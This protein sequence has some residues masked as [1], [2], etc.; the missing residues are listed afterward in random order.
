M[1]KALKLTFILLLIIFPSKVLAAG[2]SVSPSSISMTTG[3]TKTFS[4]VCTDCE[5]AV[6]VSSSNSSVASVSSVSKD[7]WIDS[8]GTTVTLKG[9]SA[10]SANIVVNLA[11]VSDIN[12]DMMSGTRTVSVTVSNPAS[13]GGGSSTP[14][15]TAPPSTPVVNLSSNNNLSSLSVSGCTLS[16]SFSSN[17]TSYTCSEVDAASINI[18]AT[19]ED[20]KAS[21]S[22]VGTRYL[23]YGDNTLYVTVTAENGSK[24]S[25]TVK[26]PRKDTRNAD[27]T[28]SSLTI[29]GQTI[30][31]DKDKTEYKLEVA[32]KVEYLQIDAKATDSKATVTG[33]GKINLQTGENKIE[34]VVKAENESTKTYV[35]NCTRS[36]KE[37]IASTTLTSLKFNDKQIDLSSDSKIFLIGLD[38]Y[39]DSIKLEYETSS[40]TTEYNVKGTDNL[41]EGINKITIEVTDKKCKK[42][43]YTIYVY[44]PAKEVVKSLEGI[45]KINSNIIYNSSQYKNQIISKDVVNLINKKDN[46]LTYNIV[47]DNNGLLYSFIFDK[48]SKLSKTLEL[49]FIKVS[50]EPLKFVSNIPKNV[51]IKAHIDEAY[52]NGTK[53]KLYTYDQKNNKYILIKDNVKVENGYITF[54]SDG[55]SEYIL[56][57]DGLKVKT[58][59]KEWII[60]FICILVGALIPILIYIIRKNF[61][62]KEIKEEIIP[63]EEPKKENIK[64][65]LEE[66]DFER[67]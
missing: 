6:V 44:V 36:E 57:T 18:S 32:S 66:A 43:T 41:K 48:N 45:D 60:R 65:I 12:G 52:K 4:I 29:E 19:K 49:K 39:K 25:Y 24:K 21:I 53:L 27:N 26:V 11:N 28:L 67:I 47:N 37:N 62:K 16:P 64:D 31:F 34:I 61:K 35:I 1:K 2:A 54:I 14:T 22:G 13:S 56:S 33:T 5:G 20:S 63:L 9:V 15:P 10:G 38:E 46:Q 51:Q 58:T 3:Q 8:A 42:V 30:K 40:N 17:K 7:G 23:N 59:L 55:S 50:D